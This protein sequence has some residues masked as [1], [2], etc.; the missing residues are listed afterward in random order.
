MKNN[1][2]MTPL[3]TF[4]KFGRPDYQDGL[5]MAPE[6]FFAVF[7]LLPKP[8]LC[9]DTKVTVNDHTPHLKL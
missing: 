5:N 8:A 6:P 3:L 1:S 2:F 7:E 9:D 4:F